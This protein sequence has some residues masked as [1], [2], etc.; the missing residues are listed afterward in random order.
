MTDSIDSIEILTADLVFLTTES[1]K[2][3]YAGDGYCDTGYGN[4]TAKTGNS[5][6]SRTMTVRIE[7][8]TANL[9]HSITA[10]RRYVSWPVVES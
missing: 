3:L 10:S 5:F 6:S 1:S 8:L 2:G 9:W 7:I 4:M